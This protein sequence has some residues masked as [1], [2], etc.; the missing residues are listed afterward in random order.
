MW[1]SHGL[2]SSCIKIFSCPPDQ[3][4]LFKWVITT[5]M[6]WGRCLPFALFHMYVC[7]FIFCWVATDHLMSENSAPVW[8]PYCLRIE[9]IVCIHSWGCLVRELWSALV[10]WR[11][12]VQPSEPLFS[13]LFIYKVDENEQIWNL[14]LE[15][16]ANTFPEAPGSGF[17]LWTGFVFLFVGLPSPTA[18]VLRVIVF[19]IPHI[20]FML[21]L[22]SIS[23]V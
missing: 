3:V 2:L 14:R 23:Q 10:G 6:R 11:H 21:N 16:W 4:K 20:L 7:I 17:V 19:L 12:S 18:L 9:Q 22:L 15:S 5:Q 13:C 1:H 8:N